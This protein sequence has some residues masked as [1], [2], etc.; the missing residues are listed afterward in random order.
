MRDRIDIGPVPAEESCA[1]L[2]SD[3]YHRVWRAECR[4]FCAQLLRVFGPEPEGARLIITS[5]PH[6][7]GTYHDVAVLYETDNVAALDW[8]LR[9]E[10]DTPAEWDNA[11]RAE[12]LKA[13][14]CTAMG[15]EHDTLGCVEVLYP[16]ITVGAVLQHKAR[17]SSNS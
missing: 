7:F 1:Q 5:N 9:I 16:P 12:L 6:D 14:V 4:A 3:R 2:G 13:G 11:A 8:A 10:G 17:S 15:C